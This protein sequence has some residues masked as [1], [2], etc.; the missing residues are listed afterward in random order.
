M[1]W[2]CFFTCFVEQPTS[3]DVSIVS[4]CLKCKPSSLLLR[5][6]FE[7]NINKSNICFYFYFSFI[8]FYIH[9][10]GFSTPCTTFHEFF[11]VFLLYITSV[12]SDLYIFLIGLHNFRKQGPINI[13]ILE[14]IDIFSNT[15]HH[16]TPTTIPQLLNFGQT[17]YLG[18]G[19][20][21]KKGKF[22]RLVL[23]LI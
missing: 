10:G 21:C 6:R 13:W 7:F 23:I 16:H 14:W 2:K 15:L 8:F 1:V 11:F 22:N 17:F 18:M 4:G 19:L 9:F 3:R 12:K 5:I 20:I